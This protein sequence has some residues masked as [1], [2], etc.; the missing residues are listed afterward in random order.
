MLVLA[1]AASPGTPPAVRCVSE[2]CFRRVEALALTTDGA[3][4]P[5]C[6]EQRHL[7]REGDPATQIQFGSLSFPAQ[8]QALRG[9]MAGRRTYCE[10]GFN[11]GHSALSI[12]QSN[13]AAVVHK[14]S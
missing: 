8:Q 7:P 14:S 5:R 9:A 11:G 6:S 4:W 13:A 1:G 10:T 2:E 3:P 12:L